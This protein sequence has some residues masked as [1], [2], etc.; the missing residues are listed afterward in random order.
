MPRLHTGGPN[1]CYLCADCGALR[2]GVYRGGAIAERRWHHAPDGLLLN[3][4][5]EKA[6][7]FLKARKS[8][9]LGMCGL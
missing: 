7:N 1:R 4:V 8:E 3:A 5:G 6:L 2:E 9:Q